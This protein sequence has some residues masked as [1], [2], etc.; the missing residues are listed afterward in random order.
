MEWMEEDPGLPIK[1]G[2]C[3]N[4]EYDPEP[5]SPVVAE[6]ISRAR[7][8]CERKARRSGMSR[9]E[10]LLSLCGAA[11]TLLALDAC[12]REALRRVSTGATPGGGYAIP[13]EATTEPDAAREAIGGEELVFDLQGHLLEYD[14]DPATRDTGFWR[15]F[16]QQGCGDDDPRA[17]FSMDHFM[18]EFFLRSDTSMVAL[19]GLPIAPE[20]SPLS[21]E[22]M[23]EARRVAAGLCGDERVVLHALT[24]PNVG[25]LDAN[26]DA[27]E[28]AVG[29]YRIAAWK[30]FTH[31]PDLYTGGDQGWWLDDH[32]DGLPQ[33]GERFIRK[34]VELGVPRICTH[35]GLSGGS[36]L[37]APVDIGPAA[38][39]HPDVS[40][41][42]YHSGFESGT[43]EGPYTAATANVGANRLITSLK[44]AGIAP[45]ENVYAE[46]GT[47][48]WN[49]MRSPTQA[50]HV[51]GKLLRYVGEA[52]VLW[53]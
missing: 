47:T 15:S 28:E 45:N 9:R 50:A 13:P 16:P 46:L 12:T 25:P 41:I 22:I 39:V 3:S 37:A 43:A 34:T 51:L 7:D 23:D 24:L 6:A 30:T 49:L 38:R 44:R 52:N 5:L 26:L 8:D 35:K 11:T 19:S 31:Y 14:I 27:M 4:A 48:W 32:E 17:C 36:R 33:V 18:E 21:P 29:R 20:G 2:P 1:F 42:V 53:G 40:F 10:F